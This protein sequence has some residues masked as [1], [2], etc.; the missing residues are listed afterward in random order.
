MTTGPCILRTLALMV[1]N[2]LT[3]SSAAKALTGRSTLRARMVSRWSP[4][5]VVITA[6]TPS[7]PTGSSATVTGKP[8]RAS[9][10]IPPLRPG[11]L[12]TRYGMLSLSI[13]FDH[14]PS[15]RTS[16][17][18]SASTVFTQSST[19]GRASGALPTS[20]DTMRIRSSE[21]GCGCSS[22][23]MGAISATLRMAAATKMA[24]DTREYPKPVTTAAA[25][26]ITVSGRRQ[27]ASTSSG[28]QVA[29]SRPSTVARVAVHPARNMMNPNVRV[30]EPVAMLVVPWVVGGIS[31][32]GR[33]RSRRATRHTCDHSRWRV[34]TR[35]RIPPRPVG[36]TACSVIAGR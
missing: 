19:A 10:S 18:M 20:S 22:R 11:S 25:T 6:S 8:L 4:T 14:V 2:R 33:R 32:R 13:T 30:S 5:V 17:T 15:A 12:T 26:R 28:H 34:S 9:T 27:S 31:H 16:T 35:H 24:A 3:R 36:P 1:S 21:F 29:P 23:Y 7:N